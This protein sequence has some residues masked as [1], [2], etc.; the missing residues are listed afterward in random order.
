MRKAL[1]LLSLLVWRAT[2]GFMGI[3]GFAM[4][5]SI[6]S[7]NRIATVKHATG[8]ANPKSSIDSIQGGVRIL[9]LVNVL[10]VVVFLKNPPTPTAC[11]HATT[12][13]YLT[14]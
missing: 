6:C 3:M 4:T 14:Y 9:S 10:T 5:N 12:K 1:A 8:C 2:K 11:L 7:W 13:P